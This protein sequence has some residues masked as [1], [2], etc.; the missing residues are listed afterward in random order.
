MNSA[1]GSQQVCDTS[2]EQTERHNRLSR[3]LQL[4]LQTVSIVEAL[5]E[6]VPQIALQ[7]RVGFFGG[8]LTQWVFILSVSISALCVLKAMATFLWSY[9]D[10][11]DVLKNLQK[12]YVIRFQVRSATS[13]APQGEGW[14]IATAAEVRDNPELMAKEKSGMGVWYIANLAGD[15][16]VH[17]AAR[18]FG[19]SQ[20]GEHGGGHI[21]Y[22]YK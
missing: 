4:Y 9:A 6:S 18:G 14:S 20:R 21:M 5:V 19:V 3:R 22:S 7:V 10:I 8:E 17:G 11:R 2:S 15:M 13:P 1:P 12:Q 16:E